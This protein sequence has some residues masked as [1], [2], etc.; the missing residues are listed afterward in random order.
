MNNFVKKINENI[1]NGEDLLEDINKVILKIM[2]IVI[3]LQLRII[4]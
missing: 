3:I 1:K 4:Y 2:I